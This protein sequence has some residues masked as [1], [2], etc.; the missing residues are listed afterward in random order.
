MLVLSDRP[1]DSPFS[2]SI[3]FSSYFSFISLLPSSPSSPSP[4][5]DPSFLLL[6]LS[7]FLLLTS[8]QNLPKTPLQAANPL[9]LY[10]YPIPSPLS[11][12]NC[13]I[14]KVIHI[15]LVIHTLQS[16]LSTFLKSYPHYSTSLPLSTPN[17]FF[18]CCFSP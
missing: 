17:L 4:S 11:I 6:L 3:T 7:L 10:Q 9:L 5:S 16:H 14:H 8:T 18:A 15:I 13:F 2:T 12:I 1:L